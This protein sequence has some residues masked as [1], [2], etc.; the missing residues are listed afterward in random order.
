MENVYVQ[1]LEEGTKVYRPVPATH[2]T[3]DV[4]R[5]SGI[6]NYDPEDEKWE[7]LP[8]ELVIV[9]KREIGGELLLVAVSSFKPS[10]G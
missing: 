5:L 4:Y 8:G 6:E 10:G 3:G 9:G 2:L 7:F 1:L